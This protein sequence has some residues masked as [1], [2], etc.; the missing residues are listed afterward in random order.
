MEDPMQVVKE[1]A[2]DGD[3]WKIMFTTQRE[4]K[5]Q[6]ALRRLHVAVEGKTSEQCARAVLD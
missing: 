1:Q 5:L 2:E 4:Q 3:L 6:A